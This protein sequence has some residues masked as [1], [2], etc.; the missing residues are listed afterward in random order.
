MARQ[1]IRDYEFDASAGTIKVQGRWSIDELL[2]VVNAQDNVII[3][4][5]SDPGKKASAAFTSGGNAKW[6]APLDG[7]ITTFTLTFDTS[8]MDD[9]DPLAVYL[10][11]IG[12]GVKVRPWDFGTDAIERI[13]VSNPVSLI[14]ADFEY[15]LQESKWQDLGQNSNIPSFYAV[16]G[17]GYSVTAVSSNGASPYSTITVTT[18]NGVPAVGDPVSVTGTL[19]Q[20]AEGLFVTI[21]SN[22]TTQFT[23]LAKSQ[24]GSGTN[25]IFTPYVEIKKGGVYSGASLDLLSATGDGASNVTLVFNSNHGLFPGSPLYVSDSTAGAQAHEGSFFVN[26]I[27]DGK[28]VIYDAGQ[29][30]TSGAISNLTVYAKNDSFFVHRPFDGGVQVGPFLP[31]SGLEAK[32]Q[33]KRYFRYQSGKGILFSTG[34]LFCPGYDLLSLTYSSPDITITTD[35]IHG[36]QVGAEVTVSDVVSTNYN[37]VYIVKEVVSDTVFKVAANVAPSDATAILGEQPRISVSKWTGG[38]VKCGIFDDSNGMYWGYDG[39]QLG[40]AIRTST[41]Q[42]AGTCSATNGSATVTGTNTR[43]TDQLRYGDTVILR[44]QVFRISGVISDTEISVAPNYRGVT[45]AGIKM[46]KRLERRIPQSAFNMDKIDGTGPSGY[47]F[48]PTRMQMLAIQ[49]TWYGAGFVDFM[50]RG[51]RGEMIT[52]HRESNNNVNF[53]AYM[54]SGNLPARYEV[55]NFSALGD[56]AT[57]SGTSGD[58]QLVSTAEFPDASATYPQWVTINSTI[59]GDVITEICSY[60][61]KND[62]TNTLTGV[63]RAADYNQFVAGASR[64]FKGTATAR[65]HV[66]GSRVT[67]LNTTCAPS[68]SH[69]GSAVIMDGG[70]DQDT[71]Y[72][73]SLTDFDITV[74]SGTTETILLFRP[75]PSVSNTL[76]GTLGQRE[77]INRSVI[78]LQSMEIQCDRNIEIVGVLNPRNVGSVT[79]SNCREQTL[80]AG[81]NVSQPS[82]AQFAANSEFDAAPENGEILFRYINPASRTVKQVY[83]LT[84]VKSVENSILGGNTVYPDGPEVIA[85]VVRNRS[86]QSALVD[87]SIKWTEEQA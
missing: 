50:L 74:A 20:L 59:S 38:S 17:A 79:W 73:F 72:L 42:V 77:I 11:D 47:D 22:G 36:V 40:V 24:V 58:L 28:T 46:T 52:A 86:N 27:V 43:F 35:G 65:D 5:F 1:Q 29:T 71:G 32:R 10:E 39:Q 56:L 14:D 16:P 55:I 33:T 23:Y 82:F 12:N 83:D 75:A 25:S 80:G 85:F 13:R 4:N 31:M 44:G 67:L 3:Y 54:R 61:G 69:W 9:S 18:T 78:K 53:E 6:P 64:T 87:I 15:G 19:N 2:M 57:S 7:G 34:T 63:T 70:F 8:A 21:T 51:P 76:P 60:T 45:A 68:I 37:G 62:L 30:V 49:Y 26:E 48:D 66:A 81:I 41:A 84:D